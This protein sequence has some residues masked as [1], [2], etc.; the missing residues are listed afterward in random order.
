[1]SKSNLMGLLIVPAVLI[2]SSVNAALVG[3]LPATSGGTDWQ[4]YY[5]DQLDITWLGN[6]NSNGSDTWSAQTAWASSLTVSGVGGWRLPDMDINNDGVIAD[7]SVSTQASCKDNELGH[8][9]YYGEGTTL[10]GGIKPANPGPFANIQAN[11]Y[12]SGTV[13]DGNATDAWFFGFVGGGE[14][15][16]TKTTNK[17]AWAVHDGK[18]S[19]VP[20][21]A[22]IWLFGSGL[23][24]LS[25]MARSRL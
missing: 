6:A 1:M 17:F 5:D 16:I 7:C 14:S 15:H 4:A 8:L 2:T 25:G 11:D 10:N 13:F 20:L 22:A 9:F 3:V 24:G 23:I 12:W 21:P 19:A 18:V